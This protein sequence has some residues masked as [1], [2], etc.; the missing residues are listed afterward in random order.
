MFS[1]VAEQPKDENPN[2]KR[3]RKTVFSDRE[4]SEDSEDR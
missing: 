1:E 3:R 4:Y 2:L